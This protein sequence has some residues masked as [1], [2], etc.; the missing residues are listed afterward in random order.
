[1]RTG[2][3]AAATTALVLGMSLP[4][5]AAAEDY[6]VDTS[7][8][9][10]ELTILGQDVLTVAQTSAT[11]DGTPMASSE[12]VAATLAGE[13][14]PDGTSSVSVTS[15]Q[16]T[17][18]QNC[19]VPSLPAEFEVVV[20]LDLLCSTSQA[21]V[22]GL[23]TASSRAGVG[24]IDVDAAGLADTITALLLTPIQA[25][26]ETTFE[27][28]EN[29]VNGAV[30]EA[31]EEAC[32]TAAVPLTEVQQAIEEITGGA[33]E[34]V[35]GTLPDNDACTVLVQFVTD[36]PQLTDVQAV[37]D[38]LVASVLDAIVDLTDV[39]LSL[40]AT[41]EVAATADV[42]QGTSSFGTVSLALPSLEL[43]GDA[44]ALAF[45][46][47]VGAYLGELEAAVSGL[48]GD[49]PALPP[50][51]E[52][53]TQVLDDLGLTP[54]LEDP[55]ALL[56]LDVTGSRASVEVDVAASTITPTA[57]AGAIAA[58]LSPSLATLL[59]VD[60]TTTVGP[61]DEFILLEG[62]PLESRLAVGAASTDATSATGEL[63]TLELFRTID[64]GGISLVVGQTA[65][66]GA[67]AAPVAPAPALPA[68]GGGLAM[69]GLAVLGLARF[70][71]RG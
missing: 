1:M 38:A 64:G 35:T 65:A 45:E 69:A 7:A 22:S 53:I 33:L 25:N 24:T 55:A 66:V 10:I 56:T 44:V 43:L 4:A 40:D 37:V 63:V 39:T 34:P 59:G 52:T 12:G 2:F 48:A 31:L 26:L 58:T 18:G 21:A 42:L 68:T 41:S 49:A 15:G 47:P 70:L 46:G 19:A 23:P 67:A 17:D 28:V 9:G 61:G 27:T 14:F 16:E 32:A 51:A 57:T 50:L 6:R 62:T 13:P 30:Q 60:Q 11:V 20:D 8:S 3:A 36:A 5:G 29:E 54:L 71:R